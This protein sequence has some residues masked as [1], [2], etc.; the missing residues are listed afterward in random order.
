MSLKHTSRVARRMA[1]RSEE[2]IINAQTR[3]RLI[4]GGSRQMMKMSK[5]GLLPRRQNVDDK[6]G[7]SGTGRS[8]KSLHS[9]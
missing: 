4:R 6:G 7:G 8:L 2:H 3:E 5:I 1:R 9:H